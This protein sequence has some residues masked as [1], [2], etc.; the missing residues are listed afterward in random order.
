MSAF[1]VSETTIQQI[2]AHVYRKVNNTTARLEFGTV[3][4]VKGLPCRDIDKALSD[5]GLEMWQM[6]AAAVGQ[7]YF[8]SPLDMPNRFRFKLSTPSKVQSFKSLQCFL[9]QC[10][11]GDVPERKL[12]KDLEELSG[13]L[14]REIVYSLP[15]WNKAEWAA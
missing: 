6:N 14:A 12:F 11:E 15:E 13:S 4:M 10:S 3:S 7:R 2:L 9:Y 8:D 5:L 1:M